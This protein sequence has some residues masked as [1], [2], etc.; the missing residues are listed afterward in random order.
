VQT[1]VDLNR[2]NVDGHSGET[3]GGGGGETI[4]EYEDESDTL[5]INDSINDLNVSQTGSLSMADAR[6]EAFLRQETDCL[7]NLERLMDERLNVD[8]IINEMTHGFLDKNL[9]TI[10]KCQTPNLES[11]CWGHLKKNTAPTLA[12]TEAGVLLSPVDHLD[13]TSFTIHELLSK[14][15]TAYC[16]FFSWPHTNIRLSDFQAHLSIDLV[17]SNQNALEY[18]IKEEVSPTARRLRINFAPVKPAGLVK[19]TVKFKNN[20]VKN[21]PFN[22]FKINEGAV[23]Q[24]AA[25]NGSLNNSNN[26]NKSQGKLY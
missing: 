1:Y 10:A 23:K 20:H 17:D 8:T 13:H 24:L 4:L 26:N 12:I 19:L 9:V 6:A 5:M 25:S 2:Q 21:S 3:N 14:T 7:T 16:A 15:D 22:I 18:E 11:V